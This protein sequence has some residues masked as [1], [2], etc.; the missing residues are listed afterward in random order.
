MN[1]FINYNRFMYSGLVS[2]SS[3]SSEGRKIGVEA[4]KQTGGVDNRHAVGG[5]TDA[6]LHFSN[7][8]ALL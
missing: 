8:F 4:M 1:I 5:I 6:R 3:R 2:R 7:G